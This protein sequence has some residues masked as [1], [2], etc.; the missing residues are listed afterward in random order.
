VQNAPDVSV[1]PSAAGHVE[2]ALKLRDGVLELPRSQL[3][4]NT[5]DIS[6]IMCFICIA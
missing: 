3:M 6:D 5:V 2:E 4:L 1:V